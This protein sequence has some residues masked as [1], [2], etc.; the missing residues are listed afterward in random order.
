MREILENTYYN[1]TLFDWT[2]SLLMILASIVL[3]KILYYIIKRFVKSATAKTSSTLDDLLVE[4]LEDPIVVFVVLIGASFAIKQ[5]VFPE[6]LDIWL[7]RVVYIAV[8]INFTWLISRLFDALIREYIVPLTE[9]TE[10]DFDDQII[11]IARK[12]IRSMIW[13][14]GIILALNNAGY[15]VAALLAG[16][17]LGGLALAMAAKDTV[18]NIF[19]GI[20]V[21]TDKPFKVYDRV[22]INGYDGI[23]EEVGIRSTR[24]RTL[25]GRII[26]VPNHYFTD[27]ILE[28]VSSEPSRKVKLELGLVYDTQPEEMEKAIQILKEIHAKDAALNEKI[29]LTFDQF[30]DFS[31]GITFIYY[32]MPEFDIPETQSRVNLEILKQF[33]AAGLSFAFPTQTIITQQS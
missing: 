15:D 7:N 22:K 29:W 4:T 9:K 21:F 20:T 10:S 14:L 33:N 24:I 26:T 19:G 13:I 2:K 32:I 28:N 27:N 11:P 30:G 18:S 8:T 23:V 12:G 16:L 5:L 25:E 3:A 6:W 17:G 1:N 31:L